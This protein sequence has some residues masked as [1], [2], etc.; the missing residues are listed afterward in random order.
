MTGF[1]PSIIDRKSFRLGGIGLGSVGLYLLLVWRYSLSPS[2]TDPRASWASMVAP[3]GLNVAQHL[4][5]Y[6]GLTLLYLMALRS[7]AAPNGDGPLPGHSH[8]QVRLIIITWLTCSGV[9]MAV[10]PGGESHDIFDYLFR[11]RMMV[12]YQGNPL[13]DVPKTYGLSAPYTRYLA[14]RKNVDTY[15]PLWEAASAAVAGSTRQ[16]ARWLGWWGEYPASCP[17]SPESCRLL[18]TYLSGYRLLAVSLT[19]LSGW[20]IFIVVKRSR[21]A[22]ALQALVAWLWCP[23]TLMAT[24]VGGHNDAVMI[25]LLL[26]S[27][28]FLQ[29][30]RPFWAVMALILA[31]HVKL[32]ALIWLPACALWIVWRW[33]WGRAFKVGLASAAGGL[34]LSW[35]LYAPLGGWQT[36]PRMLHERSLYLANSPWRI[37]NY[38]LLNRW[39]WQTESARQLTIGLANWLFIA[40]ALLIPLWMF[41]FR[42]KRWRDAQITLGEGNQVLWRALT[43]ISILYLLVGSFWFQHWYV[44]W[45]LVPAVLLPDSYLTRTVLPWL[46]F[47][48]LSSNM[49]MS[50]LAAM[51]LKP[52]PSIINYTLPVAM[53]WVPTLIAISITGL[54]QRRGSILG[55]NNKLSRQVG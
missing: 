44:L 11:G 6:L 45:A 4:A 48:A 40:G 49:A 30:Q 14:W 1:L 26:V 16:V 8:R 36:L 12:E 18:I 21:P 50:F 19:G 9:L 5:I 25:V 32:T 28:W 15:G 42:P 29:R 35:L 10:A 38:M 3:T 23:M 24:A 37:F 33:G 51:V 20:L 43:A 53:I 52:G 7:L 47:G 39:G 2:L 17:K 22:L 54:A 46:A 34:I 31:A 27:W 13:V 41:N 55:R